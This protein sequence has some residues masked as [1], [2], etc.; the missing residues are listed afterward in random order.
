M[1]CLHSTQIR[2]ELT[3]P[4]TPKSNEVAGRALGLLQENAMAMRDSSMYMKGKT[5]WA[6]ALNMA[7]DISNYYCSTSS[8]TRGKSPLEM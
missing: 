4:D 1:P 8:S 6:E 5:F 2:F 7:C 3:T